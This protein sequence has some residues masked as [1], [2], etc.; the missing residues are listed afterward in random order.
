MRGGFELDGQ[1]LAH[2]DR[3]SVCIASANRDPSAFPDPDE[4]ILDRFPNRHASFGL[5]IHRCLGSHVARAMIQLMLRHTLARVPD[6]VIDEA[7]ARPY[8]SPIVNGWIT[9]PATFTPGQ[10]QALIATL[11]V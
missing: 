2:G 10:P 3:V 9:M 11:P 7:G 8:G 6:Y 1:E 4:M 5:G